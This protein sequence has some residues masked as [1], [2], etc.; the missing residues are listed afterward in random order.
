M[1]GGKDTVSTMKNSF[2]IS[3]LDISNQK[4]Q[5]NSNI[6]LDKKQT[7]QISQEIEKNP[8]IK[9]KIKTE[10]ESQIETKY[11]IDTL[12]K[13]YPQN[14]SLEYNGSLYVT[15]ILVGELDL[16]FSKLAE[17]DFD[18]AYNL[19][20]TRFKYFEFP[21]TPE[22]K[23]ELYSKYLS[24]IDNPQDNLNLIFSIN[25]FT[26][27]KYNDYEDFYKISI[28]PYTEKQKQKQKGG[29]PPEPEIIPKRIMPEKIIGTGARDII[30]TG[31]GLVGTFFSLEAIN[32]AFGMPVDSITISAATLIS[33]TIGVRNILSG[34][35]KVVDSSKPLLPNAVRI[36]LNASQEV[37]S[38]NT[39]TISKYVT[40]YNS[41]ISGLI[42]QQLRQQYSIYSSKCFLDSVS[43]IN[44]VPFENL[45]RQ[46]ITFQTDAGYLIEAFTQ[47]TVEEEDA[48]V[49]PPDFIT[50]EQILQNF[51]TIQDGSLV[52]T[53]EGKTELSKLYSLQ[54]NLIRE[55][56]KTIYLQNLPDGVTSNKVNIFT[57][58][59]NNKLTP[60]P[61]APKIEKRE[62]KSVTCPICDKKFRFFPQDGY[63]H[64]IIGD[65]EVDEE[66]EELRKQN[67]DLEITEQ[68]RITV[69]EQISFYTKLNIFPCRQLIKVFTPEQKTNPEFI[70]NSNFGEDN[71]GTKL[72]CSVCCL[73]SLN[74]LD[75][76]VQQLYVGAQ[77]DKILFIPQDIFSLIVDLTPKELEKT[78]SRK[79]NEHR[80]AK[81]KFGQYKQNNDILTEQISKL[82]E[83]NN[84]SE[85]QLRE[86]AYQQLKIIQCP[87]CAREDFGRFYKTFNKKDIEI[88]FLHCNRCGLSFNGC[89]F[90]KPY[91]ISNVQ[92]KR[93]L[94]STDVCEFYNSEKL[95][96]RR[97]NGKALVRMEV[98]KNFKRAEISSRWQ[99]KFQQINEL[100]TKKCPH[101]NTPTANINGCSAMHCTNCNQNFCYVCSKAVAGHGGHDASHFLTDIA[102]PFGGWYGIQC[103]NVNFTII[104][105]D[106]N[107][108]N[109]YGYRQNGQDVRPNPDFK[110]LTRITWKKFN[111]LKDKY[112]G[113]GFNEEQQLQ[114]L[115]QGN[116]T[117]SRMDS[118]Y[119]NPDFDVCY[120]QG[121]LNYD[122]DVLARD[123]INKYISR[124]DLG[125]E[126][127]IL[128]A[129]NVDPNDIE[130]YLQEEGDQM[131]GD[132]PQPNVAPQPPN[133]VPQPPIAVPQPPNAVP[134][135]PIAVPQPPNAGVQE[136]N[137]EI[138][139]LAGELDDIEL[140]INL[141]L[142][143]GVIHNDAPNVLDEED[144][145]DIQNIIDAQ[146]IEAAEAV[147]AIQLVN[148]VQLEEDARIAQ[149]AQLDEERNLGHELE[150]LELIELFHQMPEENNQNDDL[151]VPENFNQLDVAQQMQL[152]NQNLELE[153]AAQIRQNQERWDEIIH[154]AQEYY[155]ERQAAGDEKL[156][157]Y[158]QGITRMQQY[159]EENVLIPQ[160][161]NII[162]RQM[163]SECTINHY[164][165]IFQQQNIT[166]MCLYHMY[167]TNNHLILFKRAD[168]TY[169][170][171]DGRVTILYPE[172]NKCLPV[173]FE[174]LNQLVN[175]YNNNVFGGLFNVT[176]ENIIN[177]QDA[178]L[179]LYARINVQQNAG[180]NSFTKKN[181]KQ[182]KYTKTKKSIKK[183][184]KKSIKK[185]FKNRKNKKTKKN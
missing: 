33:Q 157:Q 1:K 34:I 59:L 10:I 180:K 93:F 178:L 181:I 49:I 44:S 119:Y 183:Q 156:P 14:I 149:D 88:M 152:I 171:Q 169:I 84:V 61:P 111:Y 66:I 144:L 142:M 120:E 163:I 159:K 67:N 143:D 64:Q 5:P 85:E 182:K 173:T 15:P 131:I 127:P 179:Y 32:Y 58:Q 151:A 20:M 18:K 30:E 167:F 40:E 168:G 60:A 137:N 154:M 12:I 108:G 135:P 184:S 42:S 114:Q 160:P 35:G 2:V 129:A 132:V 95:A 122:P 38:V 23:A 118:V 83:T 176:L 28:T 161:A 123:E 158:Q 150:M 55:R 25:L 50:N 39:D 31:I 98:F 51:I 56:I 130:A 112:R 162:V 4:M 155:N 65:D 36:A 139:E 121:D 90:N 19:F 136:E 24:I 177:D 99:Q 27:M 48:P 77:A 100:S 6:N 71:N 3:N 41:K 47:E 96:A 138:N 9:T 70:F 172:Q 7:I 97:Q 102:T 63:I 87:N 26:L 117:W 145:E 134:Q 74:Q 73:N 69:E 81:T 107:R 125:L 105:P 185:Q 54:R 124:C 29:Q 148:Q 86:L 53:E 153:Q 72:M 21:N 68:L 133:A 89:D 103:V 164:L 8:E 80:L 91:L 165:N 82:R 146:E 110:M 79:Y 113:L 75:D 170:T 175:N 45:K 115:D 37:V 116:E 46:T 78:Y 166:H 16:K 92:F 141:A 147:N 140:A 11:D 43:K 13:L 126:R 94:N 22:A 57:M 109:N 76:S 52:L 101:C 62:F 106:G 174:N 17:N 104:D 128:N